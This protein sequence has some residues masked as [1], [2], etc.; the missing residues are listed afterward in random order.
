VNVNEKTIDLDE[1]RADRDEYARRLQDAMAGTE[2]H[3]DEVIIPRGRPVPVGDGPPKDVTR[4][5]PK[6]G[7]KRGKKAA[8]HA[9]HLPRNQ[10]RQIRDGRKGTVLGALR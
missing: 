5:P 4:V 7:K 2:T 9:P 10:A 8:A 1:V 3:D 6:R